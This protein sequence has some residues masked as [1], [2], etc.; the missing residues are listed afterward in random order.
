MLQ[1]DG[2]LFTIKL[3]YEELDYLQ[4]S[5]EVNLRRSELDEVLLRILPEE[6]GAQ[7]FLDGNGYELVSHLHFGGKEDARMWARFES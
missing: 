7:V 1:P 5:L 3:G 2:T 6:G 4:Q